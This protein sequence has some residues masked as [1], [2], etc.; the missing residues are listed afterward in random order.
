MPSFFRADYTVQNPLGLAIPGANIAVLNQPANF[1]SQPGSPLATIYAAPNSNSAT[2]IAASWSGQQIT[3]TF[4]TTP[5]SDVVE[6]SYIAVSGV[7]PSTYNTT[8]EA[9][10]LVVEVDGNNVIVTA[11]NSPGTYGSGGTVA[12]S[13]LPNPTFTDG[14]GN[15]FFYTLPGIYSVQIYE[16][17]ITERDLEDQDVGTVA[18][19]SVLSVGETGD[20]VIFNT[21]VG[22]SPVT[23][24][25]TLVPA[26][27]T[28]TANLF[29]AGPGAGSPATPTFRA[30]VAADLPG[31]TGSVSSVAL[32]LA[33][34]GILTQSV[35]GSP[36]TTSGTLAATIGL[37][38]QAANLVF[39]GPSSGGSGLPTFRGLVVA[40]IPLTGYA[41]F[42][43][44]VFEGPQQ[45]LA[46]N[47]SGSADAIV[48]PG[49][50]F[51]TTAGVDATSLATPVAGGPGTGDDGKIVRI[52]DVGGHA[53]TVTASSNKIVPS[54]S[55]IT[56]GGTAGSY[57]E[58]EAFGGFWYPMQ[59]SGVTIS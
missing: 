24:T 36:I 35:T 54:H 19:G 59:N 17:T 41:T 15:G 18:G 25:G 6:G 11:L 37:A 50:N 45:D 13:V 12:T 53:H 58:L 21:T 43:A 47:L 39:A 55:L 22:G 1:S 44:T 42:Q 51:I 34:P 14:N 28:Q 52:F 23:S 31:G 2:I 32:T 16:P 7:T 56:F 5:P 49:S 30:I 48:F 46:T 26:L 10:Y 40:D 29:L 9:P 8:L 38:T 57:I 20:G 4:S 27:L 3:F 33:V